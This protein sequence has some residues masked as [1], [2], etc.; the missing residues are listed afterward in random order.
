MTF[1]A[2]A[3]DDLAALQ[4]NVA[5]TQNQA[6]RR[7]PL[8][9][10]SQGW[11]LRAMSTPSAGDLRSGD[12]RIFGLDDKLCVQDSS[13]RV[14]TVEE[15]VEPPPPPM[16]PAVSNPPGLSLPSNPPSSYNP[17]TI[18][19]IHDDLTMLRNKII[20]ILNSLRS[21]PVIRT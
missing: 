7:E 18:T 17:A 6:G 4:Q 12:V 19:A 13:G 5:A 14:I 16:G 9:E 11:I 8:T 2:D 20:E 3:R 10:T 21:A 1:P 15:P